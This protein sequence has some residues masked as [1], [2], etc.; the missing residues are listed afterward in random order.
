[1]VLTN[2]SNHY[3]PWQCPE[4]LIRVV[5]LKAAAG[6]SIPLYG[7]GLKVRDLMYVENHVDALLLAACEGES[8]RSYCVGGYGER[9]IRVVV[10]CICSYLDYLK[11]DG[12]PHAKMITRVTDRPVHDRRHAIHPT[13][14]ETELGRSPRHDF[15]TATKA[16][17]RCYLHPQSW[18]QNI[19]NGSKAF[20]DCA[21]LAWKAKSPKNKLIML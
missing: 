14:I 2:C 15:S 12:A 9:T 7:D 18:S 20:N 21:M 3:G 19:L 8:G 17:V 4:N 6:K 13:R 10:D 5:T 1:M 16:T 11:P